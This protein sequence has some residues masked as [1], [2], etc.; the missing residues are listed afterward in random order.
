M[1]RNNQYE[2]I[3]IIRSWAWIITCDIFRTYS[4]WLTWTKSSPHGLFTRFH[5]APPENIILPIFEHS[6]WSIVR[7]ENI[8]SWIMIPLFMAVDSAYSRFAAIFFFFF[9]LII[10]ATIG[11]NRKKSRAFKFAAFSIRFNRSR[12][13]R[14]RFKRVV[15]EFY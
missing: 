2:I 12:Y 13:S 9:F 7:R 15:F 14:D 5:G 3:L 11:I 4:F 8:E 6:E 1:K 10:L